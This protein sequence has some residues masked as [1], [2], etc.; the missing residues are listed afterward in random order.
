MT[1]DTIQFVLAVVRNAWEREVA[2]L[3][4]DPERP[5]ADEERLLLLRELQTVGPSAA[6]GAA[7]WAALQ[8]LDGSEG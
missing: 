1:S 3:G 7:T 5:T 8:E 2:A 4:G 6:Y